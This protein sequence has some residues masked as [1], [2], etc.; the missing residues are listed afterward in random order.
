[1]DYII[2]SLLTIIVGLILWRLK[3][4]LTHKLNPDIKLKKAPKNLLKHITPGVTLE[5]V[6]ELLSAPYFDDTN[7]MIYKFKN[8]NLEIRK[9]GKRV[10]TIILILKKFGIGRK[11]PIHPTQFTLGKVTLGDVLESQKNLGVET[12]SKHGQIWIERYFGNPGY[13]RYYTFGIFNGPSA[14]YPYDFP[15]FSTSN[16]TFAGVG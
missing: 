6:R 14:I 15:D 3:D 12:S 10:S 5:K 9:D 8:V 7:K 2:T 4:W 16:S 1:M 13:Y 11:Y